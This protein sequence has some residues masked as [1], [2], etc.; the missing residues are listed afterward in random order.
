MIDQKAEKQIKYVLKAL[1]KNSFCTNMKTEDDILLFR[2]GINNFVFSPP[3]KKVRKVIGA[4]KTTN[5][6]KFKSFDGD[7]IT[8]SIYNV[9]AEFM[10]K[11]FPEDNISIMSFNETHGFEKEQ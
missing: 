3:G 11:H 10:K 4:L 5:D 8:P 7:T 6:E 1:K 9:I 2:I